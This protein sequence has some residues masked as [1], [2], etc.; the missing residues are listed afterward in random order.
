M[1]TLW[2]LGIFK[3]EKSLVYRDVHDLG[4]ALVRY[5]IAILYAL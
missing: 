4:L 2:P 1:G 3:T 5:E